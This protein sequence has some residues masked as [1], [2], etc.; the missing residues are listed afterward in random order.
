MILSMNIRLKYNYY[1]N[2]NIFN[3]KYKRVVMILFKNLWG[4]LV[5]IKDEK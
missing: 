3:V 1:K 4:Y 2:Y 5:F